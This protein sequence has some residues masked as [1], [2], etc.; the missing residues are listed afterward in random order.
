MCVSAKLKFVWMVRWVSVHRG[1]R[2]R[3]E[4]QDRNQGSGTLLGE[5]SRRLGRQ[6]GQAQQIV[7]SPAEEKSQSTFPVHAAS[8]DAAARSASAT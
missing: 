7:R 1:S 6:S 4:D 8:P 3:R 2:A 5:L